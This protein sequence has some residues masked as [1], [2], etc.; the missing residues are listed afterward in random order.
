[1]GT[2]LQDIADEIADYAVGER[3]NAGMYLLVREFA[4][5]LMTRRGLWGW[6]EWQPIETAPKDGTRILVTFQ[7]FQDETRQSCVRWSKGKGWLVGIDR[8][9]RIALYLNRH[10]PTRWQPLPDPPPSSLPSP[11]RQEQ[12]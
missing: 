3:N 10:T 1:M 4:L 7:N 8:T 9:S 11:N 12:P 6:G 2:E 5:D